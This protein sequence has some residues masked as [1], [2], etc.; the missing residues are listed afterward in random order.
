MQGSRISRGSREEFEA[1]DY[2]SY[3]VE[4]KEIDTWKEVFD[5]F[6]TD[7]DG[8]LAPRDLL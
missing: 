4:E 3:F 5:L 7:Q 8:V 2:V 1:R 6:D